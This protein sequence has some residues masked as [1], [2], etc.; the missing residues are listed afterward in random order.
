[1][2]I[3]VS[4]G[5][6]STLSQRVMMKDHKGNSFS[7]S[8]LFQTLG[9]ILIAIFGFLFQDMNYPTPFPMIQNFVLMAIL[10]G[11]GSALMFKAFE[12]IEASEFTILFSLSTVFSIVGATIFLGE[13]LLA[14]QVLG[15]ALI[16]LGVILVSYKS[17][18]FK[19]KKGEIFTLI[20]AFCFGLAIVNDRYIL[21]TSDFNLFPFLTLGYFL[22]VIPMAL[23]KP[24]AITEMKIFLKINVLAKILIF[25]GLYIVHSI[26]F[27][28]ALDRSGNTSQ[29]SS[30]SKVS[31]I[32]TVLLAIILLR[33]RDNLV[34]KV[35]G[36]I[37]AFGGLLLLTYV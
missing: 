24:K 10:Y 25:T 14:P 3:S 2:I 29:I 15:V 27:Y 5:S 22:P 6:F 16:L 21:S 28:L 19:L 8:I 12:D 36:V 17:F 4:F 26:S 35:I 13:G 34:R 37:L 18:K 1:M 30:V 9:A 11:L 32:L 31:T 20:A 7:F 23:I 33:E